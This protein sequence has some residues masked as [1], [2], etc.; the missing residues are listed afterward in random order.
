MRVTVRPRSKLENLRAS[1]PSAC[2]A[3]VLD[4][5]AVRR[6]MR[7]VER[8]FHVA[9]FTSLRA[10]A[11]TL[12]RVNVDG[13]RIVLEEALR[14]GVERAVHT[15]SIAAIGPAERGRPPTRRRLGAAASGFR[16]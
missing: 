9:G 12:Y 11:D 15:S 10:S 1:T 4:R 14:A 13:T 7:G 8:V 3:D 5:R 16:T 2:S 6:A